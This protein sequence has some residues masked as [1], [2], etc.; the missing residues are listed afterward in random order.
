MK[1]ILVF[2]VACSISALQIFAQQPA[3]LVHKT[4]QTATLSPEKSKM[5]CIAWKLDSVE[6]FG[7]VHPPN[8]KEKSDAITFISDGTYF[9]TSEGI[10]ASGTWLCNGSA[11]INTVSKQAT[12]GAAETKMMYKIISL[13]ANKFVFDYQTPDLITV[14]YTYIPKN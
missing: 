8:S 10:S 4:A 3:K 12:A 11:Y 5:L 9:I 1:T 13:S 2:S 14:R 6:M 7:V